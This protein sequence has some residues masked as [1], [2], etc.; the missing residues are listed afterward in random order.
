VEAF[1]LLDPD[2]YRALLKDAKFSA[3]RQKAINK[4][5]ERLVDIFIKLVGKGRVKI[6]LEQCR[7]VIEQAAELADLMRSS[8]TSYY[9]TAPIGLQSDGPGPQ[10]IDSHALLSFE[11]IDADTMKTVKNAEEA[12]FGREGNVGHL[13]EVVSLGLGRCGS[14][15][16]RKMALVKSRALV[17]FFEPLPKNKKR[18]L[19]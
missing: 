3:L 1:R 18:R 12:L 19:I 9:F 5:A 2:A 11:A 15:E 4:H 6:G 14:S 8:C 10:S 17:R 16:K 13:L 7:H